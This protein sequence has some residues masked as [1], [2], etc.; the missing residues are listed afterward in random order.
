MR[1]NDVF[2]N[3]TKGAIEIDY[4]LALSLFLIFFAL[5]VQ[6]ITDYFTTVR[7]GTAVAAARSEAMSL[8]GIADR[9]PEPAGWPQITNLSN[10]LVLLM[11]FNNDT[12]DYSGK[13]NNGTASGGVNC[14]HSITGR[15]FGACSFDG[16]NDYVN[17]TDSVPLNFTTSNFTLSAWI[18]ISSGTGSRDI[19]SKGGSGNTDKG[20]WLIVNGDDGIEAGLTDGS[21]TRAYGS[22]SSAVVD[23]NW[24]HVAAV[25]NRNGNLIIYIDGEADGTPASITSEGDV[26]SA[27]MLAVG[28]LSSSGAEYFN[29]IIDEVAVWNRSLS[30]GEINGLY[31]QRLNLLGLRT[32]AFRFIVVVNNTK[33]NLVNTS[34]DALAVGLANETVTF[35]LSAFGFS[36]IDYNSVS[37]YNST[38]GQLPFMINGSNITFRTNIAA[39][40]SQQFTVYFDDDSAFGEKSQE[41]TGVN[42]LTETFFHVEKIYAVQYEKMRQ[43]NASNYTNIRSTADTESNF[44]IKLSDADTNAT[45]MD[46][47]A[48]VPRRGNI[49]ALQRHVVYQN[50]TAGVNNG[51]ITVQTW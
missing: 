14:S 19:I 6:Y 31:Q 4:I 34:E 17:V 3:G 20:Y 22:S 29:G 13:G 18:K 41:I 43:L 24:H 47:G 25:F 26:S 35:N 5:T 27:Y 49:V 46:Y 42:N 50:S 33:P 28:R 2:L 45:I 1:K 15:F 12:L 36:G 9:S 30:A 38:D 21:V 11:H 44:H 8:L 7:E 51:K 16:A 32:G 10:D 37:I 48:A 23:G 40:E 39:N